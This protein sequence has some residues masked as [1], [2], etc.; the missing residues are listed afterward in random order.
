MR[1][2]VGRVREDVRIPVNR[3]SIRRADLNATI[4][5]VH[6][7]W[8]TPMR[9]RAP[10]AAGLDN[11]FFAALDSLHRDVALRHGDVARY[12]AD[13]APFI[14]VAHAGVEVGEA[15]DALVPGEDEALLL[16]VAPARMPAGWRLDPFADLAQMVCDSPL[17]AVDG[18]RIVELGE[19]DRDDVLALVALVYPHYFRR[20]TMRL[21]RYFG[22]RH[23]GELAAIIGERLGMHDAREMSAICTHPDFLGRGYARRLTAFLANDT[24]R[25]G[26]LPFLHVSHANTRAKGLYERQGWRMRRDIPFWRLARA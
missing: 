18:P 2:G 14:G 26:R 1:P 15:F 6:Q 10:R 4:I 21:G 13:I 22:I 5:A 16:G 17:P 7:T 9:P 23:E 3:A 8:P 24:L 20:R 12:P 11:P 19:G 25:S